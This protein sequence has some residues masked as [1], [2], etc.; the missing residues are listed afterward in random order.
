MRILT[1]LAAA[2]LLGGCAGE[3]AHEPG[4]VVS[5]TIGVA[6]RSSREGVIVSGVGQGSPAQRAGI[7]VGDRL[8][9]YNGAAIGEVRQFERLVLE[10]V[11][12]SVVHVEVSRGGAVRTLNVPV[13][14]VRTAIRV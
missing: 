6:V 8:L 5:G 10:S 11:P 14:Q 7:E 2:I 12:G 4:S 3:P 9:R 1:V 13:E